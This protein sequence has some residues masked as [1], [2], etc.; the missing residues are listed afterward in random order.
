MEADDTGVPPHD[1]EYHIDALRKFEQTQRRIKAP[2]HGGLEADDAGLPQHDL[3]YH[4]EALRKLD[5]L[6]QRVKELRTGSRKN[7]KKCINETLEPAGFDV[8]SFLTNTLAMVYP[9]W[10][11]E[12]PIDDGKVEEIT[13]KASCQ[14][15]LEELNKWEGSIIASGRLM[16]VLAASGKYA[17][18]RSTFHCWYILIR[19][20][21]SASA[22]DWSIGAA[23]AGQGRNAKVSAY[24]TGHAIRGVLLLAGALDATGD[25]LEELHAFENKVTELEKT[26][27]PEEWKS[28]ERERLVLSHQVSVKAL[29]GHTILEWKYDPPESCDLPDGTEAIDQAL[30][31]S[32]EEALKAVNDCLAEVKSHREAEDKE[33]TDANRE[34]ERARRFNESNSGHSIAHSAL[35]RTG[36]DIRDALKLL[37][38]GKRD[39]V[40]KKFKA[41]ANRIKLGVDP[42]CIYLRSVI[43]RQLGAMDGTSSDRN[44]AELALSALAYSELPSTKDSLRPLLV[45][46]LTRVCDE[47]TEDGHLAQKIQP[48]HALDDSTGWIFSHSYVLIALARLMRRLQ[49]R[50]PKSLTEKILNF[51]E[52]S[53]REIRA[54]KELVYGWSF[55]GGDPSAEAHGTGLALLTL[56]E[57]EGLLS[58]TMNQ[59]ILEHFSVKKPDQIPMGLDDLYYPDFGFCSA[60]D[61][62][63]LESGSRKGIQRES[64]AQQ[65]QKMRRHI[66]LHDTRVSDFSLAL[67]GPA[68]TG[69]TTLVEAL[70]KSC[71]VPMVEITPSDIAKRGEADIEQR[72][73]AVFEAL[74]MLT[75]V[76]I[77]FDEFDPI[78]KRRILD[79]RRPFNMFSFLTPGMLPKLKTLH[80]AAKENYTC[81]V[82]ITNLIG[83]LDEAAVREGRFDNKYGI[84]PPDPLSRYGR[85]F[86]VNKGAEHFPAQRVLEIIRATAGLG[87]T[88]MASRKGWFRPLGNE[89][90][91]GTLTGYAMGQDPLPNMPDA[92]E[93][94]EEK[95]KGSGQHAKKEYAEWGWLM[96][97]EEDIKSKEPNLTL[98]G[99]SGWP[100]GERSIAALKA[101]MDAADSLQLKAERQ[102]KE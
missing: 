91:A 56:E 57:L 65:L 87:M 81:Y 31:K 97:W 15:S 14:I 76:V 17:L 52:H 37:K 59:I 88:A 48:Y 32:L 19:E 38:A 18:S 86:R 42:A 55:G 64:I 8:A 12:S 95:L 29:I 24:V 51:F 74:S 82:L 26:S 10:L 4:I 71:G 92:E 6:R 7:F 98:E 35:T 54:E 23:R 69:K 85:F 1:L 72:A 62:I 67:Y 43:D 66:V 2:R 53:K 49:L 44:P 9:A 99:I 47:L 11:S 60:P 63:K 68:G 20:L 78:L 89:R 79:D 80:E 21:F 100:S 90:A 102:Q 83:T 93:H 41:A 73:R 40:A 39:E 58:E 36:P 28:V 77:L 16:Q 50:V 70:A 75:R 45:R 22:P 25:L 94:F 33:L 84:Y 3:E 46:A 5:Q 34:R 61:I 27:C 96:D 101:R 13:S 30:I